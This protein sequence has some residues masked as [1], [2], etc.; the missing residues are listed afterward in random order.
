MDFT[1]KKYTELCQ[2]ISDSNY[3]SLT[4]QDY[5]SANNTPN[6]TVLLRHDVDRN[7]KNAVKLAELEN[8]LDL[9]ATYYFRTTQKVFRKECMD[10]IAQLGH[11]IG[12]HYEV[13]DKT[14]GDFDK[15][16]KLFHTEL[17]MFN[18]YNVRTICM[19]GNPLSAFDNKNLWKKYDFKDFGII[20]EAYLSF[21]FDKVSYFTDTGRAW[22]SGYSIKDKVSAPLTKLGSTD[23]LVNLVKSNKLKDIYI[24]T[25]PCR[26]NDNYLYWTKELIWQNL[27]NVAKRMIVGMGD[28]NE[29]V[30]N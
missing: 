17:E 13:L 23:E 20:G 24:L 2:A 4:I 25:H 12:Y 19:H 18:K 30:G 5:L 1:L 27:K 3:A 7:P 15:A 28:S 21:D 14:K 26:W 8:S 10:K 16:I 6:K 11:E 29:S 22:N 9:N